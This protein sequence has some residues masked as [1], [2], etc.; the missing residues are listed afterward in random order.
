MHMLR[1]RSFARRFGLADED[2]IKMFAM[3]KVMRIPM[4]HVFLW[5][6]IPMTDTNSRYFRFALRNFQKSFGVGHKRTN[7]SLTRASKRVR[8][9]ALSLRLSLEEVTHE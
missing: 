4:K 6:G 3:H 1:W 2:F 7:P 9:K 8:A 5:A